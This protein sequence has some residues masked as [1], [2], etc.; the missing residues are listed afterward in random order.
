MGLIRKRGSK[1][2]NGIFT[3]SEDGEIGPGTLIL[4]E[5]R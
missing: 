1:K 3:L 5:M 2:G 4:R